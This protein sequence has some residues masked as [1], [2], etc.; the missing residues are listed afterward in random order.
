MKDRF[1]NLLTDRD[2]WSH[3]PEVTDRRRGESRPDGRESGP[4]DA[5]IDTGR[6]GERRA[7]GVERRARSLIHATRLLLHA[8]RESDSVTDAI[9]SS[10]LRTLHRLLCGL[11]PAL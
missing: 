2:V 1:P 8:S 4:A 6:H 11:T 7:D 5:A 3:L 9:D 10:R